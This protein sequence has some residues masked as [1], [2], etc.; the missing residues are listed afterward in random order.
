M[1]HLASYKRG[2]AVGILRHDERTAF[3]KV[4]AR[5]TE[6][7]APEKTHLN[8]NL[9]DPRKGT[10]EQHIQTVCG[11]NNVRLSNHKDLNV[12]SSCV[13]SCPSDFAPGEQKKFF[14]ETHYFLADNY[15]NDSVLS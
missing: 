7:I 11:N 1:A 10:L 3:D 2:G 8:Y 12:M 14:E 9:A 15:G 4:H 13:L 5:K 6:T